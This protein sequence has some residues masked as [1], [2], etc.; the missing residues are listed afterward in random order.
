MLGTIVH[1]CERAAFHEGRQHASSQ[2]HAGLGVGRPGVQGGKVLRVSPN[3]SPMARTMMIKSPRNTH[4]QMVSM[5]LPSAAHFRLNCWP[6]LREKVA[7]KRQGIE[8]FHG[9]RFM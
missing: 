3:V 7:G 9:P 8:L 6:S 2:Q 4:R 5:V 1:T